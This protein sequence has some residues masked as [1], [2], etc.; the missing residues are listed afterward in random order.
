MISLEMVDK[1]IEATKKFG[2]ITIIALVL[3][4]ITAYRID[5]AVISIDEMI[6]MHTAD[7]SYIFKELGKTNSILRQVCINTAET[8]TDRNACFQ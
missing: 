2:P 1:T 3:V 4:Y 7:T 6:R 5:N 8:S